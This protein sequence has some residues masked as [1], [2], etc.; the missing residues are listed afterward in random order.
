M[1]FM[2]VPAKT[3]FLFVLFA[4]P[5]FAQT[6]LLRFPDVYGDRVVFS[7]A[8][9]LWV[10]PASGGAATRLTAHP[11]MEVFAK[12][13]PDGRWIAFRFFRIFG[14]R[15]RGFHRL[16]FTSNLLSIFA[17]ANQLLP[18]FMLRKPREREA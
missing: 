17:Q 9:D 1:F 3:A 10:S 6:K 18:V 14:A 15:S 11:G 4:L 13:S 8:S 5:V 16:L 7:Y 12:F 2:R